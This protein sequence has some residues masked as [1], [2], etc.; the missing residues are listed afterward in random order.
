MIRKHSRIDYS[1]LDELASQCAKKGSIIVYLYAPQNV[2]LSRRMREQ[3]DIKI[4]QKHY[5]ILCEEYASLMQRLSHQLPILWLE[6]TKSKQEML[7]SVYDFYQ[8]K[9]FNLV[10]VGNISRDKH[11]DTGNEYWGGSAFHSAIASAL[12]G[13]KKIG[14]ISGIGKDFDEEIFKTLDIININ[15]K[16]KQENCNV[17]LTDSENSSFKLVGEHY[18]PYPSVTERIFTQHLHISLRKGVPV[19]DILNNPMIRY[20][21]LSVDVIYSSIDYALDMICRFN[22]HISLIFCNLKEYEKI[23]DHIPSVLTFVTNEYR[24]VSLWKNGN[25]QQMFTVPFCDK[26]IRADGAGDNFIGGFLSIPT[27]KDLH[28]NIVRGIAMAWSAITCKKRYELTHQ[29]LSFALREVEDSNI[30]SIKKLPKHIIVIGNPCS[31]KTAFADYMI[32]YFSNYYTSI[33]DYGALCDVFTLDD[34]IRSTSNI[35]AILGEFKLK[36]KAQMVV[37]DYLNSYQNSAFV[38]SLYTIPNSNGGHDILRPELWDIII[39]ESL[40]DLSND[41]NY[42]FQLSRGT[43]QQYMCY[44]SISKQQ[45]YDDALLMIIRKLKCLANEILIVNLTA[46]YET[47]ILRNRHRALCGGHYVSDLAMKNIYGEDVLAQRGPNKTGILTIDTFSVPYITVDN[48]LEVNN[49]SKHFWEI[50]QIV[51]DGY[52]SILDN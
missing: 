24:P 49:I 48:S 40:L 52:N 7:D 31:G 46:N 47:R 29:E 35:L 28:D 50:T 21:S 25:L 6:A 38:S 41:K 32:D 17:F 45:V 26:V 27:K 5:D 11:I 33:D 8:E 3:N 13:E 1:Q 51:L 4:L 2:L 36:K 12:F 37:N 34:C 9:Q 10:Y 18:L 44:K 20:D 15:G 43:D 14:I 30:K 22:E 23:K 42:I 39:E 16:I 19:E